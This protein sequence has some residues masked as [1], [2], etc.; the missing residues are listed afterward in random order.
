MSGRI[1][2]NGRDVGSFV[3]KIE[4]VNN[5]VDVGSDL[6]LGF[7]LSRKVSA[8]PTPL[9]G[10]YSLELYPHEIEWTASGIVFLIWLQCLGARG[11]FRAFLP[12][13]LLAEA[14]IFRRRPLKMP[15]LDSSCEPV[16]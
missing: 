16:A 11:E 5:E 6:P 14:W 15:R 7:D 4:L 8:F 1:T 9:E 12:N 13:R 10:T 2:F 3:G